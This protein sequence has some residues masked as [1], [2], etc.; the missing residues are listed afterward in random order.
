M[1]SVVQYCRG[2]SRSVCALFNWNCWDA[3]DK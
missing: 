3:D 2:S 1:N